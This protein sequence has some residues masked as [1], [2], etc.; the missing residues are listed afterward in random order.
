M[1]NIAS[2]RLAI[3]L[4]YSEKWD[5]M[6]MS[7]SY[8]EMAVLGEYD[9]KVGN[10]GHATMSVIDFEGAEFLYAHGEATMGN[11]SGVVRLGG[12]ELVSAS[13]KATFYGVDN[14]NTRL[15]GDMSILDGSHNITIILDYSEKWDAMSMSSSYDNMTVLG[16]YDVK[17]G[18][19]GHATMSVID[20]EGAEFLYAHGEATMGNGSGVVRLGGTELVSASTKATFY[21]VD[22]SNTR[23]NGDMSILDSSH[24]ITIILDYSE[25]WDAMSMSGSYNEMAV[26]GEYDVKVDNHGHATMSVIDFEGAEFLY[27]HG[28]ATE[29]WR[30]R[31][32]CGD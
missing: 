23:L 17:V 24:N 12:T 27:A 7:G 3:I 29:L 14:S 9:V 19:H 26:L 8:N 21:G 13:T 31:I 15:N 16:E 28:E 18:N 4:D 11:G 32:W 2:G 30:Q 25:K 5:M 1:H 20:F 6:S 10:H 22:N